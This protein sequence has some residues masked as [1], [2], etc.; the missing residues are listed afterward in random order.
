MEIEDVSWLSGHSSRC[1]RCSNTRDASLKWSWIKGIPHLSLECN[2]RLHRKQRLDLKRS[3]IVQTVYLSI[4]YYALKFSRESL[5]VSQA[6]ALWWCL[7]SALNNSDLPGTYIFQ[8]AIGSEIAI[9]P[10]ILGKN[11]TTWFLKG[12]TFTVICSL[13][14]IWI[15]Q[16]CISFC[17][18]AGITSCDLSLSLSLQAT[19]IYKKFQNLNAV[20]QIVFMML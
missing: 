1:Y 14:V 16:H 5:M 20:I 15:S 18:Y 12:L 11:N 9:K 17:G 7:Q 3:E 6:V 19:T 2:I 4:I 10:C 13:S 8:P